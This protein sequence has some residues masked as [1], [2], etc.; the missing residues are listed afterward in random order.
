MQLDPTSYSALT[1][2]N[3]VVT[4]DDRDIAYR[5]FGSGPDMV[6][7]LRFRGTMDMWD[8]L[9]LDSLAQ[10]FR[11]TVF[12]YSGLGYSTGTPS[13]A[14]V[15]MAK[16]VNDLVTALGYETVII[17]G[18]SLGGFAAMTFTAMYPEKVS[19][20]LAIGTMPPGP[21]VKP[22]EQLFFE[23]AGKP[24]Y[25]REDEHILFFEPISELSRQLGDRSIARI[26]SRTEVTDLATPA[27]VFM[28]S[29]AAAT[30]PSSPYPDHD[31]SYR[32]F[33]ERT[34]IPVLALSGDHDIIFPVEN[35]YALNQIWPTLFV[36][37]YPRSG[38]GPQHQY[39]VMAAEMITSF[40]RHT[41]RKMPTSEKNKRREALTD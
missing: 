40:V 16:D 32:D 13:Y 24:Q 1:A 9:F 2:P 34:D 25:S 22:Y 39:P 27:E 8:P 30:D 23:T 31:R 12:D 21:M 36:V 38:H 7:C 35:W 41:A 28:T 5:T 4:V 20:V 19:H 18:W 17:G 11:V 6:L 15:A 3:Q 29:V 14:K 10:N 26:A 37:T 33:F